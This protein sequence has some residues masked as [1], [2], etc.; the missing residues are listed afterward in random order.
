MT[1]ILEEED[2]EDD[3]FDMELSTLPEEGAKDMMDL[4]M[5]LEELKQELIEEKQRS[6]MLEV[7][8]RE[9]VSAE[10]A[11]QLVEIEQDFE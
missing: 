6:A 7:K 4:E 1:K 11:E 10:M 2:M 3:A 5:E 8:I 9:E